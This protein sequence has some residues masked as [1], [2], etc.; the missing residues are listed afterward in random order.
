MVL[1]H[2]DSAREFIISYQCWKIQNFHDT[3]KRPVFCNAT[4]H[5]R[6]RCGEENR[7]QRINPLRF[8]QSVSHIGTGIGDEIN[9]CRMRGKIN[10][11][12]YH[13]IYLSIHKDLVEATLCNNSNIYKLVKNT[14][15][16]TP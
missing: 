10:G 5:I 2:P 15:I 12:Y 8:A 6:R 3:C 1:I 7:H 16:Y 4:R 9:L 14:I 11:E 13:R